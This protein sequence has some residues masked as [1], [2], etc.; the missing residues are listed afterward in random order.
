MLCSR[1]PTPGGVGALLPA[2]DRK[3]M[4]YGDGS[5]EWFGAKSSWRRMDA[6]RSDPISEQ[7]HLQL[8]AFELAQQAIGFHVIAHEGLA[9]GG[10]LEQEQ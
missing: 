5:N 7:R 1:D 10:H 4:F 2:L 3:Q 8:D 9:Q 6:L